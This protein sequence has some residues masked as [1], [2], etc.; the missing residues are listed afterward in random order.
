LLAKHIGKSKKLFITRNYVV[1][2]I[3]IFGNET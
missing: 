1:R 3:A 2:V